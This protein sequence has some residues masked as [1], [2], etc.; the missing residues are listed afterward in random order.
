M[1]RQSIKVSLMVVSSECVVRETGER[2]TEREKEK[3]SSENF[4]FCPFPLS[5]APFLDTPGP[6]PGKLFFF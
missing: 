4:F 1:L 5:F 2:E 3:G 6:S